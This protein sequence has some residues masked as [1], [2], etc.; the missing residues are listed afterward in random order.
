MH[1]SL[2][3]ESENKFKGGVA[4]RSLHHAPFKVLPGLDAEANERPI[5]LRVTV[6]PWRSERSLE[7]HLR[8]LAIRRVGHLEVLPRLRPSD[9]GREH[10][11]EAP[12]VRVV[13]THRVVVI[14]A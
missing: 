1:V 13:V 5:A 10:R 3:V 7:L 14:R 6:P 9:L 2:R 8:R 12:D 11:R 4:E